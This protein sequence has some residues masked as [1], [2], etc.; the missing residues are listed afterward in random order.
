MVP[1]YPG[2]LESGGADW[3]QVPRVLDRNY[4]FHASFPAG[5]LIFARK[6][7]DGGGG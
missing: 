7:S 2:E 6:F 5:V 4:I 3:R 1:M